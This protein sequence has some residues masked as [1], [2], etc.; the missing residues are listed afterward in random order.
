[1]LKFA[2]TAKELSCIIGSLFIELES[3]CALCEDKEQIIICGTSYTGQRAVL[4]IGKDGLYFDGDAE[5]LNEIRK[6]RCIS[7]AKR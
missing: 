7:G 6:T 3:P 2:C 1:M 5:D 4:F